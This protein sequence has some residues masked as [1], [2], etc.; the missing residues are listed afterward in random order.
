MCWETGAPTRTFP[1]AV[2]CCPL[3]S[4]P[5]PQQPTQWGRS[6]HPSPSLRAGH[7]VIIQQASLLAFSTPGSLLSFFFSPLFRTQLPAL[8]SIAASA[9]SPSQALPALSARALGD[10]RSIC[11]DNRICFANNILSDVLGSPEQG[12]LGETLEGHEASDGSRRAI[13]P[14]GISSPPPPA[15]REV[16]RSPAGTSFAFSLEISKLGAAGNCSPGR[17]ETPRILIFHMR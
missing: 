5:C 2:P 12:A 7:S 11:A 3:R 17:Q 8:L 4:L 14:A 13:G 6:Q 10:H 9:P 16:R 15:R 1:P